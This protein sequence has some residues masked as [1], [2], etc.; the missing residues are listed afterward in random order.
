MAKQIAMEVCETRLKKKKLTKTLIS[1]VYA[2]KN[3]QAFKHVK[4]SDPLK[5]GQLIFK[6]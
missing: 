1:N 5:T 3:L 4:K 2:K 6:F